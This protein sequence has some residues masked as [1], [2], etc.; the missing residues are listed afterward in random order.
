[1][2][3]RIS[4]IRFSLDALRRIGWHEY[5]LR[6]ALGGLVTV[7]T[8]LIAKGFG[9]HVGGLFLAFPAIFPASVTLI[10]KHERL[11]KERKGLN[12][13]RRGRQ[14]A[15]RDAAGSVLGAVGLLFFGAWVW[16]A[17]PH[18]PAAAVLVC[19]AAIWFAFSLA[20]WSRR[21]ACVLSWARGAPPR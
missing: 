14:V 5:A 9:P 4:S 12:G 11:K 3:S 16:Q 13:S 19:G 6:F 2:S 21:K 8:G 20:L 1:M 10:A 15:A 7:A 17:L 18:M